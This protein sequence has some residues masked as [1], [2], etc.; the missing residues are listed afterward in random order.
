MNPNNKISVL[1]SPAEFARFDA[2][3]RTKGYK[4]STLAAR[5]I[6]E[7]MDGESFASETVTTTSSQL[8]ESPRKHLKRRTARR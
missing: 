3:C 8:P 2:Y 5:L 7:H 4:K 6:R 1:L